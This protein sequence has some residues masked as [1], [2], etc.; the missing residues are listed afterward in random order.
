L[1]VDV[2]DGGGVAMTV[3][4]P[5]TLLD[6]GLMA[7]LRLP[8][9]SCLAL[10][11]LAVPPRKSERTAPLGEERSTCRNAVSRADLPGALLA[12]M[13]VRLTKESTKTPSEA[14]QVTTGGRPQSKSGEPWSTIS[15][16]FSF[17]LCAPTTPQPCLPD[18]VLNFELPISV[19]L[20]VDRKPVEA[21]H[22]LC[23]LPVG[24]SFSVNFP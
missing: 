14:E 17:I 10:S 18:F 20:R 4:E 8:S 2:E 7:N 13:S 6:V 19:I 22:D 9:V 5:V 1:Q 3:A 24:D 11:G 15:I 21:G 12:L 16:A 23:A